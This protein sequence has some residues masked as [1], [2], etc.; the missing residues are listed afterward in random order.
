LIEPI[1]D[2][3]LRGPF[4]P[5]LELLA[6]DFATHGYDLQRLIRLI[7]ATEV[8][9]LDSEAD[10][11]VGAEHEE[12]WAV[13]PLTRLRPEQV[14]GSLL[15]ACTLKTMDDRANFL[16]QLSR[17]VERNEFVQRFGDMGEDEFSD[18]G[19]TIPQRLLLMNG[20]LTHERT[21]DEL[22]MNAT[23]QIAQYA[24]DHHQAIETAYLAVLS[25]RPGEEERLHFAS[26][27]AGL[28]A[29]QLQAAIEDLYW[30][31][32]NSSEFSWNH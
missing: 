28:P 3:P 2:M 12:N 20:K 17:V 19:G 5:A 27:L 18:R 11:E 9:Q 30:V 14:A 21:R 6:T 31:L 15:Q 8:F 25:R 26:R 1:D 29:T 32:L 23:T 13:F 4:P 22:L 24:R 7:V 10:F 16:L